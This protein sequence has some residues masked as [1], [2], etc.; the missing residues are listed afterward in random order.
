MRG[1][2]DPGRAVKALNPFG[3]KI[4]D[5]TTNTLA[6]GKYCWRVEYTGD[7]VYNPGTHTDASSECFTVVD[8]NIQITPATATNAVGTNHVLTITVNALGGTIDAGPHT[9]TA[10]IVSGPG[11]FVGAEHLHLH[12]RRRDRELHRHDHLGGRRGRR[13]SRRP[14]TSR[15]TAQ[16]ITRTT[17]HGREHG[18]RRQRQREQGL[19]RREHPDHAGDRH[20]RGQHEPRADDHGQRARRHDRRRPAHGDRRDRQRPGQLRRPATPAPTPAA[21][22]RDLH[23]HDHLGRRR[24]RRSSRRRP[25]SRSAARRSRA[26]PNTAVNTAA[27]GSGNASKVWV[28]ANIQITPAT[29]TNAVDTNHVLTITVNALGG[30]I[31]AGPHTATASIVSGPGSFVGARRCTY[32]GGGGDRDLHGHD[33]LGRGRDDG[34]L[35]RPPTSRSTARRSRA[36][37]NTAVNTAAGGSGNASKVWVDANI[38]ITPATATNAVSTNHVLTITVNALGRDDRRR[39]AHR[40]RVASSAARAASSAPNTCTYTGGAAT[41]TCTVTITSA[42]SGRRSSRRRPTSRSTARRSR[43]RPN[44]A[45]NTGGRR[46][47]QREQGLG[48]REHPDHAGDRDQRGRHEPRAARSRSTRSAA[49]STPARTRRPRRS[50]AARAASSARTPAPTPAAPRPR[51]AR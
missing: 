44:T 16:T 18:R 40:D 31:D 51:P 39:P 45:V 23:G 28:D 35:R 15:S 12:R 33:H 26:P 46:Q 49:R 37:P 7:A 47:R 24:G 4:S 43:A 50:S 38:Q 2:W 9:A 27:G 34:R 25:T 19:G 36:R 32:T 14:P 1:G 8:A 6:I 30:T 13:S 5:A 20:Q 3:V 41:A 48:R 10:S 42:G 17:E 21:R 29:A 11:S 22:R